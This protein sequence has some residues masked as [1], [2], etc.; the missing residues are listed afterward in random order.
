MVEWTNIAY[1]AFA[2]GVLGIGVGWVG[3]GWTDES[4]EDEDAMDT[5]STMPTGFGQDYDPDAFMDVVFGS[6]EA[7]GAEPASSHDEVPQAQADADRSDWDDGDDWNIWD[8]DDWDDDDFA[9]AA[10]ED[11]AGGD[12]LEAPEDDPATDDTAAPV[13]TVEAAVFDVDEPGEPVNV[14]DFDASIDSLEIQYSPVTDP[15]TGETI[16]PTVSI[17][18]D[19]DADITSVAL[20]GMEVATLN[21]AAEISEQNITL[22]EMS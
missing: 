21:G 11:G 19:S 16:P 12:V 10:P 15:E 13:E 4:D 9:A 2:A 17:S 8:G 3:L 1:L 14:T 22:T 18:Y 7:A 20:N 6:G 5:F